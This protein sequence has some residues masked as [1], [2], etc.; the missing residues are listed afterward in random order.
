MTKPFANVTPNSDPGRINAA[1]LSALTAYDQ[2]QA[3][4]KYYNPYA[5]P[6]YMGALT[7]AMKAFNA[8]LDRALDPNVAMRAALVSSFT[9]RLLDVVLT[10]VSLPK[11][12]DREQRF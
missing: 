10:A 7:G 9:G 8:G 5:L 12:T 1:L 6:Q 2:R 11:S 3:R 4:S